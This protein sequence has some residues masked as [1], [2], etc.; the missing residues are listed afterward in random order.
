MINAFACRERAAAKTDPKENIA[1]LFS[2]ATSVHWG[3]WLA[4][5]YANIPE[6]HLYKNV[7]VRWG[8]PSATDIIFKHFTADVVLNITGMSYK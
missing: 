8:I 4:A 7:Q 1:L 2:N 5:I 6:L 3:V